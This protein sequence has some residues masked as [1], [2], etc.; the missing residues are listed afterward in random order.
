MDRETRKMGSPELEPEPSFLVEARTPGIETD[1]LV[2]A[3]PSAQ[4]SSTDILYQ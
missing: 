1:S 3:W 2:V 4:L